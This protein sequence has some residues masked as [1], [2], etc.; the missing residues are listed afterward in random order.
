MVNT[1]T[2][3]RSRFLMQKKSETSVCESVYSI[4]QIIDRPK[5][6][7]LIAKFTPRSS[8]KSFALHYH[9]KA[10]IKWKFIGGMMYVIIKNVFLSRQN[11][12]TVFWF[13]FVLR[14]R[15]CSSW[16][17]CLWASGEKFFKAKQTRPRS[18]VCVYLEWREVLFFI[19]L[20][21]K[22]KTTQHNVSRNNQLKK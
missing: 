9:H 5:S 15:K 3:C 20:K 4:S 14:K 21:S 18:I 11:A 19:P 10:S 7:S 12:K 17:Y 1:M 22:W 2:H 6:V 13:H 8:G 16:V